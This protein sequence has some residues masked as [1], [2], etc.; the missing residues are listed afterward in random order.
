MNKELEQFKL[1]SDLYQRVQRIIVE[2]EASD[3]IEQNQMM[4]KET[5]NSTNM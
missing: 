4:G 2:G 1:D 5:F 3:Y